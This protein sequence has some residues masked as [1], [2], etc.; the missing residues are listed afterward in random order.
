MK[1]FLIL[2]IICCLPFAE[3][4]AQYQDNKPHPNIPK[5][6]EKTKTKTK[7]KGGTVEVEKV[8]YP[9]LYEPKKHP[10][11]GRSAIIKHDMLTV[12]S[13]NWGILTGGDKAP[14]KNYFSLNM[15]F[16]KPIWCDRLVWGF[17]LD[18]GIFTGANAAW[19]A[20][21]LHSDADSLWDL[22]ASYGAGLGAS[23]AYVLKN[24]ENIA[25]T[26]GP[27]ATFRV[28]V[29]GGNI[30]AQNNTS[31]MT[32]LLAYYAGL[33]GSL[34]L[35]KHLSVSLEFAKGLTSKFENDHAD[36]VE[37]V[38]PVNYDMFRIGVGYYTFW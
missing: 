28:M 12:T 29:P 23:I 38:T 26:L 35:G 3:A 20:R 13:I 22:K 14:Q 9:L 34:Y 18:A 4:F 27:T 17:A 19:Y 1:K 36:P 16:L 31:E 8:T 21:T 30:G 24:E 33:K 37:T 5:P 6:K 2:S 10:W 15:E 7:T 32:A 11:D 25:I